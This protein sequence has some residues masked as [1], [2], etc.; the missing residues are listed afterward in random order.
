M[1]HSKLELWS[2]LISSLKH[3]VGWTEIAMNMMSVDRMQ[4]INSARPVSDVLETLEIIGKVEIKISDEE[5]T[6]ELLH[7]LSRHHRSQSKATHVNLN[8]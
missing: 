1:C 4:E 5:R 8:L 3:S 7:V 2:N 6:R